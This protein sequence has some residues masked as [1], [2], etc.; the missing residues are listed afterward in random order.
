MDLQIDEDF[1]LAPRSADEVED[2]P[3]F[4]NHSVVRMWAFVVG[5]FM[6]QYVIFKAARSC[7]TAMRWTLGMINRRIAIAAARAVAVKLAARTVN[8][9]HCSSATGIIFRFTSG[10]NFNGG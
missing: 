1:H 2:M 4:I 5:W 6:W 8:H 3:K 9:P 10:I 7:V